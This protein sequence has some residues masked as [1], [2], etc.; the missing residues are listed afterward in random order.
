[1]RTLKAQAKE[2]RLSEGGGETSCFFLGASL[3][4]AASE[5]RVVST[6]ADGRR[7]PRPWGSP[8]M[9]PRTHT[10]TQ[11]TQHTRKKKRVIIRIFI[12]LKSSLSSHTLEHSNHLHCSGYSRKPWSHQQSAASGLEFLIACKERKPE[13]IDLKRRV[14]R[15]RARER[16]SE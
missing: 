7:T 11:Q 12:S 1:M 6:R 9:Q 3:K 8:E 10:H 2:G 13:E 16:E 4:V 14:L 15:A 5:G